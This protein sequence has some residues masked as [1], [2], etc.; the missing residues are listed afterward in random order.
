MNTRQKKLAEM[1]LDHKGDY[2]VIDYY[3]QKLAC[4][5]KT[6]RNDLKVIQE[7]ISNH[8]IKA[9]LSKIPGRG[10][11]LSL[12]D[13]EVEHLAY[14][15][16]IYRLQIDSRYALFH[17]TFHKLLFSSTAISIPELA[18]M[19]FSNPNTIKYE[20]KHWETLLDNFSLSLNKGKGLR[21][22]GDEKNIRLFALYYF[23]GFSNNAFSYEFMR[24]PKEQIDYAHQHFISQLSNEM[25]VTF[26]SN[27]FLHLAMYL[28]IMI[29]RLEIQ[30][31]ITTHCQTKAHEM[32]FIH[33]VQKLF[34]QH[35]EMTLPKEECMFLL[36]LMQIGTKQLTMEQIQNFQPSAIVKNAIE[37]FIKELKKIIACSLDSLT[38][39]ALQVEFDRAITRSTNGIRVINTLYN[40]IIQKDPFLFGIVSFLFRSTPTLKALNFNRMDISRFVMIIKN[41]IDQFFLEYPKLNA[42]LI[43]NTG[44]DQLFYAKQTIEKYLPFVKIN[45]FLSP[46]QLETFAIPIDFVISFEYLSHSIYPTVY[47]D[48]L[49]TYEKLM[50]L[51]RKIKDITSNDNDLKEIVYPSVLLSKNTTY[52]LADLKV[53]LT[54][55]FN[56]RNYKIDAL[57]VQDMIDQAAFT[58]EDTLYVI[59][60][61]PDI[62]KREKIIFQL[63]RQLIVGM[64]QV[65]NVI[66]FVA[67]LN[68]VYKFYGRPDILFTRINQF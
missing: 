42:A 36:E 22:T 56:E 50:I 37:S 39:K 53:F 9:S 59:L 3:K 33:L 28:K 46:K 1:L 49:L 24:A 12:M 19:V 66:V 43:S 30:C 63:R 23:F 35:Y 26:T 57:L 5:E 31:P 34:L 10:V 68:E 7:F 45:H 15:L 13:E 62:R 40:E 64:N 8:H 14:L 17:D 58:I 2:Q 48:Y 51:K 16:D 65:V 21:I 6:I 60:L 41:N 55:F 54:K 29:G 25:K 18:E 52:Y 20:I 27:A 38:I 44:L 32:E 47:T 11:C 61:S 4:S 67:D